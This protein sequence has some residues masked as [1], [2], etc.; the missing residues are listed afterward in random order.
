MSNSGTL[1]NNDGLVSNFAGTVSNTGTLNNNDGGTLE[2]DGDLLNLGTLRNRSG[3]SFVNQGAAF[4][5]GDFKIEAG[6][7]ASGSGTYFQNFG[8]TTVDGSLA[9][10]TIK[11]SGGSLGG[12]GVVTGDVTVDGFGIIGPGSSAGTLSITGNYMQA[13]E[14]IL[15]IEIAALDSFDILDISGTATLGGTLEISLLGDYTPT[16]DEMFVFLVTG[17]G[18]FGDF[19][20]IILPSFGG[21]SFKLSDG[22]DGKLAL[23]TAPIPVPAALPMLLISLAGLGLIGWR[24]RK[25]A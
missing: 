15:F 16:V 6:A 7:A 25:A 10:S 20:N 12:S 19:A 22:T 11:I 3:S 21:L 8:T 14:A 18:I 9:Q 23:T 24:R 13:N 5:V 17:D 4:N 1:N 2:N